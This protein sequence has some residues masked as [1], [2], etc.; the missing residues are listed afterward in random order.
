MKKCIN[1]FSK[2][3]LFLFF[4]SLF[5]VIFSFIIFKNNNYLTLIASSIG[6]TSLILNAKGNPFGQI[7]MIIFSII[8]GIIS[9]SFKYYGEMITYI[10]MTLPMSIFSLI[11]WLKNPYKGKKYEVKLNTILKKEIILMFVLTLVITIIFYF[12]LKYFNTANIVFSTISI[13]TSFIAAYLTFKRCPYYSLA[14]AIND[15]ILIILWTLAT[16]EN[17]SY[18][19]L[20]ICFVIFL[21]NDLYGFINLKRM[22]EKQINSSY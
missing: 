20:I 18:T 1:Y 6:V 7:L 17:I 21:I 10:G 16:I 14:Y 19:S 8:Y 3:E 15:I 13:S 5:T 12:I 4:F 9:L 2:T 22:K 11:S